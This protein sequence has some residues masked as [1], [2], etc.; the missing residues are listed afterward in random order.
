[1]DILQK[2]LKNDCFEQIKMIYNTDEKGVKP[3]T[4]RLIT[5]VKRHQKN[6]G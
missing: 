6:K 1:M 3:Y 4:E 2:L 5:L